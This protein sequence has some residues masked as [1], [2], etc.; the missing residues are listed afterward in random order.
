MLY[1]QKSHIVMMYFRYY[2]KNMML[3]YTIYGYSIQ[4]MSEES[5]SCMLSIFKSET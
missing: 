1:A 2:S 4:S 5:R 3:G